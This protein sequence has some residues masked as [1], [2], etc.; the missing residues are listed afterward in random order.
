MTDQD[1][2]ESIESHIR[3]LDDTY[4][5]V[6]MGAAARNMSGDA[7]IFWLVL[8]I[9]FSPFV[10]IYYIN[11]WSKKRKEKELIAKWN[12]DYA[13]RERLKEENRQQKINERAK[14]SRGYAMQILEEIK[15]EEY[16]N[17][18]PFY[19]PVYESYKN[20]PTQQLELL[21]NIL[22][23]NISHASLRG[24]LRYLLSLPKD[25]I[26]TEL[27]DAKTQLAINYY[28]TKTGE[29]LIDKDPKTMGRIYEQ[30]NDEDQGE[31]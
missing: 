17:E 4:Q 24:F 26:E 3:N 20:L 8:C 30:L 19:A 12:A 21:V 13:E 6:E 22:S 15:K 25:R 16:N 10:L 9:I 11:K 1:D 29:N 5:G 31:D 18:D 27:K 7:A 23:D 2:L 28:E 14:L